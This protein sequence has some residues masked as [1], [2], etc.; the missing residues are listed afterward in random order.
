MEGNNEL[1]QEVMLHLDNVKAKRP[2]VAHL[3]EGGLELIFEKE[4]V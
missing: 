1:K 2:E 3:I 4:K